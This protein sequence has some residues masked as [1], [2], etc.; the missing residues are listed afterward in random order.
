MSSSDTDG[1]E[2][3]SSSLAGATTNN[4]NGQIKESQQER[5]N[6]LI[7]RYES[8]KQKM[9]SMDSEAHKGQAMEQILNHI[10]E[11]DEI[12]N[13]VQNDRNRDTI[14][15][16]KDAE[17]FMDTSKFAATNAR[18][19]KLDNLG[20]SISKDEFL[21]QTKKYMEQQSSP[22]SHQ[23]GDDEFHNL[24]WLRLGTLYET[25]SLKPVTNE[26]LLGALETEKKQRAP[27]AR[28][29]DDT[30][31]ATS[32]TANLLAASDI[33]NNNEKSTADMVKDVF[34]DFISK[35]D[36]HD[37]KEG[38]NFF[39]FFINPHSFPQSIENLFFT[40]FLIKDSKLK[41]YKGTDGIPYVS[42]I[43]SR[44][45][46]TDGV[47]PNNSL[48]QHHIAS[49]DYKTWQKLIKKFNITES[50]LGNRHYNEED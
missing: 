18:N 5:S 14:V 43:D 40:S 44:D 8:L 48:S 6:A 11:L 26:F 25:I 35:R 46:S 34:Q 38:I 23:K 2:D 47:S 17:A 30:K 4:G 29:I 28:N 42:L 49:L 1:S 39:K 9:N 13:L 15:Q 33:S 24:D 10:K 3:S 45:I 20:I 7:L 36:A 16:L 21:S 50:F 31:H 27:R 19:L 32:T 12:F 22:A 37:N 41:I